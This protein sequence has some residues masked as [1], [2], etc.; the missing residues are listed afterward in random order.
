MINKKKI[1][2][3]FNNSK[4]R[5]FFNLLSANIFIQILAFGSQLFVAGILSPEDI[6]RIKILQIFLS[7]FAIIG[8]F[9]LNNSIL[10]ICSENIDKNKSNLFFISGI[11]FTIIFSS[12]IY[13]IVV[14]F[15]SFG[16]ISSDSTIRSIFPLAI[17]PL[18]F[19]NIFFVF[20]AYFQAI[21]DIKLIANLTSINKLLSILL[22]I[23]FTYYWGLKGYYIA[24]NLAAI[25]IVIVFVPIGKKQINYK[26]I[27]WNN[28][29]STFKTHKTY[30][31][32]SMVAVILGEFTAYIDILIINY[33]IK[34]M[35]LVGFYSFA[36][37]L[38]VIIRLL[39]S[40]VQ[41][42]SEPYFSQLS[43]D[44]YYFT[45]AYKKYSKILIY[46]IIIICIFLLIIVPFFVHI[47]INGKYINS[48]PFFIPLSIGW[49]IRQY[50]QIQTA[51]LFGIGKI[52]Y[53]A[54]SQII[55]LVINIIILLLMIHFFGILGAAYSSIICNIINILNVYIF[56]KKGL[57][58]HFLE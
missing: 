37:T 30:S 43:T 24:Y 13:S 46:I 7:I 20:I 6:G 16:W 11:L 57:R 50:N 23:I 47:F 15:N 1:Y 31:L 4:E 39:P 53:I 51:A 41:Q 2:S 42:I 52:N 19:S 40:T 45:K 22:I 58:E 33:F 9:G 21:R 36:L 44:K 27:S 18:I 38:T 8:G 25:L 34:D 17:L 3:I 56:L 28:I 29:K 12:I 5:G 49:S 48:I 54:Y 14:L 26:R 35:T 55:S 32:P 10:K